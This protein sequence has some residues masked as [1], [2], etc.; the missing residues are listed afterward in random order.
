MADC[1]IG[2]LRWPVKLYLREQIPNP[3]TSGIIELPTEIQ[4]LH[5]D[6]QPIRAMAFYQGMNA[7]GPDAPTHTIETRWNDQVD[8]RHAFVRT[9][10]RPDGTYRVEVF[11]VR[12]SL[13][14]REGRKRRSWYE[15][16]L[17]QIDA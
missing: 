6:I 3:D 4:R 15:V 12:R 13:G 9:T 17:E 2:E 14:D 1:P 7:N 10:T 11:R 8:T 16:Q 5:A